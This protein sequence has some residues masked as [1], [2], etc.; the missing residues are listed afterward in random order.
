[1]VSEEQ[2]SEVSLLATGAGTSAIM[3][4]VGPAVVG[5]AAPGNWLRICNGVDVACGFAPCC[6]VVRRVRTTSRPSSTLVIV[7]YR[8][9]VLLCRRVLSIRLTLSTSR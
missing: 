2:R 5:A 1:M 4:V 6:A 3:G 8:V 9:R 7:S